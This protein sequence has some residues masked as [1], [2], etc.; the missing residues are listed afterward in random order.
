MRGLTQE[1]LSE[2]IHISPVFMS[3]IETA[4]RRPS[5]ETVF[6]LAKTLNVSMDIL[7]NYKIEENKIVEFIDV[8]LTREQQSILSFA[9]KQKSPAEI[10][11]LL[12]AFTYLLDFERR[13]EI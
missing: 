4:N 2:L 11:A 8:N 1:K 3:Q 10:T 13:G 9:F 6:N 12:K 7:V 5:L